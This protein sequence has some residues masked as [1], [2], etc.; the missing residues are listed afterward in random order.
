MIMIMQYMEKADRKINNR[1]Q[2]S[3]GTGGKRTESDGSMIR[4]RI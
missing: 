2:C 1:V 3:C 4:K